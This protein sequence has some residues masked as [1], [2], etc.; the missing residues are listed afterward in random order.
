MAPKIGTVSSPPSLQQQQ[1]Q[2]QQQQLKS[3]V[4]GEVPG[5]RNRLLLP[6]GLGPSK[7]RLERISRSEWSGRRL[8]AERSLDLKHRGSR[9]DECPALGAG[10]GDLYCVV[11]GEGRLVAE[12]GGKAGCRS[13]QH[14]SGDRVKPA[15]PS[16]GFNGER[17]KQQS[18]GLL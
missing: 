4:V 10:D 8:P 15:R 18:G 13:T 11:R 6:G 7:L 16:K 12:S 1:Q 9:Q 17:P 3:S 2:Q 5:L 14:G